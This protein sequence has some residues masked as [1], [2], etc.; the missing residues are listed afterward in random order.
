[1]ANR[2]YSLYVTRKRYQE[3]D[4]IYNQ[5]LQESFTSRQAEKRYFFILDPNVQLFL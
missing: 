2:K 1:M 3:L 4:E 5:V